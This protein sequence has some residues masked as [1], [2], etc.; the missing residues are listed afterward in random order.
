M[1]QHGYA[2]TAPEE[3][4]D[5]V[6]LALVRANEESTTGQ[7]DKDTMM[8]VQREVWKRGKNRLTKMQAKAVHNQV[9]E[10]LYGNP[11]H[12]VGCA[13]DQ[14][15]GTMG[16]MIINRDTFETEGYGMRPYAE[17]DG[18]ELLRPVNYQQWFDVIERTFPECGYALSAIDKTH[19]KVG[20]KRI[21]DSQIYKDVFGLVDCMNNHYIDRN[22]V[23]SQL[24]DL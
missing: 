23:G 5:R 22:L 15:L 13:V 11:D 17:Y 2:M 12:M 24:K 10:L 1:Y 20:S 3:N 4:I 18:L 6:L 14:A 8:A 19:R 16:P 21:M 9:V 7:L